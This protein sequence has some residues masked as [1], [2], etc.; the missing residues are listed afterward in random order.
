MADEF[1]QIVTCK[2]AKMPLER[3]VDSQLNTP[4]YCFRRRILQRYLPTAMQQHLDADLRVVQH[5][6]GTNEFRL[7]YRPAN[8]E[9]LSRFCDANWTREVDANSSS[10]SV[11]MKCTSTVV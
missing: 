1:L 10:T 6:A 3:D 2:S 5:L 8:T 4:R 7:T 9:V 11:A